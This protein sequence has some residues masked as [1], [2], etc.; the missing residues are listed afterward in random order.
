M[1]LSQKAMRAV[2]LVKEMVEIGADWEGVGPEEAMRIR[3]A[4]ERATKDLQEV[5]A[6]LWPFPQYPENSN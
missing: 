5:H 6:A 1:T 3:T 2:T 4:L